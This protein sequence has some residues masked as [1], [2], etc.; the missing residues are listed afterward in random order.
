M[1]SLNLFEFIYDLIISLINNVKVPNEKRVA[2]T[3]VHYPIKTYREK[4]AHD[5]V[6]GY[7][8]GLKPPNKVSYQNR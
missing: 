5:M 3:G 7:M 8:D 1:S 6:S 4:N 2:E